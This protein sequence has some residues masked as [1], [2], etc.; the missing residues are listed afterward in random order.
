MVF[1][2]SFTR[3]WCKASIKAV[4]LSFFTSQMTW[5]YRVSAATVYEKISVAYLLCIHY[6]DA[7]KLDTE[8]L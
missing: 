4:T 5:L 7:K 6:F 3:L 1:Y 8:I 2:V